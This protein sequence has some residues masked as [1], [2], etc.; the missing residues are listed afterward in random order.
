MDAPLG[1]AHT[2]VPG[3]NGEWGTVPVL[4]PVEEPCA[5]CGATRRRHGATW[6]AGH[7]WRGRPREPQPHEVVECEVVTSWTCWSCGYDNDVAGEGAAGSW[8]ECARCPEYSWLS[9]V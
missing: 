8:M 6:Q 2:A 5:E 3:W 7:S 4:G 9:L 1:Y